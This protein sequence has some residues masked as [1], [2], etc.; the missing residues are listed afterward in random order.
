MPNAS[1]AEVCG[2]CHSIVCSHGVFIG[3]LHKRCDD[4]TKKARRTI[5]IIWWETSQH[6]ND[7]DRRARS[8]ARLILGDAKWSTFPLCGKLVRFADIGNVG[9]KDGIGRCER[10]C[11]TQE[12]LRILDLA[13]VAKKTECSWC[14]LPTEPGTVLCE[15]H[16]ENCPECCGW[17]GAHEVTCSRRTN[18][19]S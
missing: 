14:D 18:G 7:D 5:P 16:R 12:A 3:L 13:H 9:V 8:H 11:R 2:I 15:G 1:H 17:R 4:L 6:G 19:D 10:C